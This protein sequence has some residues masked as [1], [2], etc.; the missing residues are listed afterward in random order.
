MSVQPC[1]WTAAELRA[2]LADA[3]RTLLVEGNQLTFVYRGDAQKVLLGGGIQEPLERLADSDV[4]VLTVA[5]RDAAKAVVSYSFLVQQ[6]GAL[7]RQGHTSSVW[8]GPEAPP[9]LAFVDPNELKGQL[10]FHRI[11]SPALLEER[12]LIVYQPPGANT[13]TIQRV[14]YMADGQC[15][16]HSVEPLILSGKLPPMTLIGVQSAAGPFASSEEDLRAQEYIP[17]RN[18]QRYAAHAQFF[19]HEVRAWAETTFGI[20]HE[21]EQ[22]AVFGFSNGAVFAAA[23]GIMYPQHFGHVLAFS[24]G[25]SP[26]LPGL[27][28]RP[29]ARFYFLAGTLEE[30][31][32]RNTRQF[33]QKLW[34]RRFTSLFRERVCGHDYLMWQEELPAALAWAFGK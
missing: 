31:F 9:P 19:V 17:D 34:R 11:F 3:D 33:A 29:R 2:H 27:L 6:G 8:R 21:R 15:P 20:A 13:T 28:S 22:C 7:E 18:A 5:I 16:A 12:E 1:P 10:S 23:A 24:M 14:V 30:G 4:W 25:V 26:P 32:H